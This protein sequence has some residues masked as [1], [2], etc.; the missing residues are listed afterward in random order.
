M[1]GNLAHN[2]AVLTC[3]NE[4]AIDFE[5]C[6]VAECSK[7]AGGSSGDGGIGHRIKITSYL[8]IFKVLRSR[9]A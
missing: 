2:H 6:L 5:T 4:Q 3:A 1:L 9:G 7:G 8:V